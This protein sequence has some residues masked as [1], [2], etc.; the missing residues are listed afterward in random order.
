MWT[1]VGIA[2]ENAKLKLQQFKEGSITA[3]Q[4]G[5]YTDLVPQLLDA[6][7]GVLTFV[8]VCSIF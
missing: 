2:L 4:L 5:P 7:L 3:D 1:V 6:A 8:F